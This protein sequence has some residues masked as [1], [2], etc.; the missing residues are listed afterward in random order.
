MDAAGAARG[1]GE[2]VGGAG[3]WGWGGVV[4]GLVDTARAARG[5]MLARVRVGPFDDRRL[6]SVF[7][8]LVVDARCARGGLAIAGC[9][10][11]R[12]NLASFAP[13]R[14]LRL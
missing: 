8:G 5:G 9:I 14:R 2:V 12:A 7:P 11:W 10:F 6:S 1:G 4:A 3:L 13:E